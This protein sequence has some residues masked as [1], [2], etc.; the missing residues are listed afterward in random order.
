MLMQVEL[1][2]GIPWF[3]LSATARV[4]RT[5]GC[6]FHPS[7]PDTHGDRM[8]QSVRCINLFANLEQESCRVA[9][10]R[11]GAICPEFSSIVNRELKAAQPH[12]A[13]GAMRPW[14]NCLKAIPDACEGHCEGAQFVDRSVNLLRFRNRSIRAA[15]RNALF[16]RFESPGSPRYIVMANSPVLKKR[17]GEKIWCFW[18]GQCDETG[19]DWRPES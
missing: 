4:S 19:G 2:A 17:T 3:L 14:Y 7:L 1:S 8:G 6:R 5:S 9:F 10:Y 12:S 18:G 16:A 11:A 13:A 15:A